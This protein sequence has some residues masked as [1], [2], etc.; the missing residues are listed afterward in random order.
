M[1]G[2]CPKNTKR[3]LEPIRSINESENISEQIT[4]YKI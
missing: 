1:W 3:G 4:Q 2:I